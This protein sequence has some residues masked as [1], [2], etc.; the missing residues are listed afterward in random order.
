MIPDITRIS[1]G[2]RPNI[3]GAS[4]GLKKTPNIFTAAEFS[5]TIFRRSQRTVLLKLNQHNTPHSLLQALLNFPKKKSHFL[6]CS[7]KLLCNC[8]SFMRHSQLQLAL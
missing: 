3:F 6:V 1:L 5:P 8:V 7:E 2:H 4:S